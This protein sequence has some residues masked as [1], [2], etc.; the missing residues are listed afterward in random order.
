V[1]T[2]PHLKIAFP[3]HSAQCINS[4]LSEW[5]ASSET[6]C[7]VHLVELVEAESLSPFNCEIGSSPQLLSEDL[8]AGIT[9]RCLNQPRNHADLI[10]VNLFTTLR[11]EKLPSD[12]GCS[13]KIPSVPIHLFIVNTTWLLSPQKSATNLH[14]VPSS[15]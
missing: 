1:K 6:S 2:T 13:E 7:F 9:L 12:H 11:F 8:T 4:N 3:R 5:A 14:L 10:E 15:F